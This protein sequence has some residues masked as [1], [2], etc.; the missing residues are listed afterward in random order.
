[1]HRTARILLFL[2]LLTT[3]AAGDRDA[4]LTVFDYRKVALVV[5]EGFTLER[6]QEA[7]NGV[8]AVRLSGPNGTIDLNLFFVPDPTGGELVKSARARKE[9]MVREFQEYVGAST[10]RAMQFEEFG[11]RG[12]SAGTYCAF[13]DSALVGKSQLPPNEF[14]HITVGVKAWP[15]GLALFKLFSNDLTSAE[16]RAL[17]AFLRD[18]VKL[19]PLTPLK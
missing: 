13:T 19:M 18:A 16:Y 6:V 4:L 11:E 12:G 14:L 2:S 7:P 15:E 17:V 8:V 5:P 1:M 10:E 9:F 3:V